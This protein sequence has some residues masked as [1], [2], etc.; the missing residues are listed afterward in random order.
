MVILYF[1]FFDINL[2]MSTGDYWLFTHPAQITP[3]PLCKI[4]HYKKVSDITWLKSGPQK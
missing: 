4:A 3:E 2:K 1:L